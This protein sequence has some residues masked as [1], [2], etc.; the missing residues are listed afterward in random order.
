[1]PEVWRKDNVTP[2]FKKG[3]KN[4][5]VSR[6]VMEELILD[7]IQEKVEEG[8]VIRNSHHGFT[9][10]KSYFNNLVAFWMS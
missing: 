1:M 10:G 4:A 3:K 8:R 9:K 2:V 6:K 7:V 5:S